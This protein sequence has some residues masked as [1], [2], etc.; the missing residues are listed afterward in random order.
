MEKSLGSQFKKAR[1]EKK[2][3]LKQAVTETNIT[4]RH[5]QALENDDYTMFPSRTYVLGFIRSY[6]AYLGL[7]SEELVQVYKNN[8]LMRSSL[9]LK[10]LTKPSVTILDYINSYLKILLIPIVVIGTGVLVYKF[11]SERNITPQNTVSSSEENNYSLEQYLIDSGKIPNE[12]TDSVSFRKDSLIALVRKNEG[13]DFLVQNTEV[14]V[15]LKNIEYKS[16]KNELSRANLQIYPGKSNFFLDENNPKQISLPLIP[17]KLSFE[18][19]GVTPNNIKIN[20]KIIGGNKGYQ[21]DEATSQ[22]EQVL[23]SENFTINLRAK[24]TGQ[25]YVEFYIDGKKKKKGMLSIGEV[26]YFQADN[27][28]QMKIGDAGAIEVIING[29]SFKEGRRGQQINKIIRK[30]KD[31][32]DQLKY[33][34][35][36][37]DT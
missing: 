7:D 27:S 1:E 17:K 14:Y 25:N 16:L 30:V 29:K 32:L 28:I 6:A 31:P 18:L 23:K 12:K 3:T 4:I 15:V 33:R 24:A 10:E 26:L 36:I 35:E 5:L 34:L 21:E 8:M 2:I 37:K 11:V 22:N 19:V 9:P 20:V 13:I